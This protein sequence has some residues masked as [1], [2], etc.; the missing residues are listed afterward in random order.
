MGSDS[1]D[2]S[3]INDKAMN[4]VGGVKNPCAAGNLAGQ[5][6]IPSIMRATSGVI[7]QLR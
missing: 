1:V 4:W 6:D 7:T 2:S 5:G 3:L